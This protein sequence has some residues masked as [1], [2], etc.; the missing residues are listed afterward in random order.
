MCR[1]RRVGDLLTPSGS[2]AQNGSFIDAVVAAEGD[3]CPVDHAEWQFQ[4]MERLAQ[5]MLA[6]GLITEHARTVAVEAYR[7]RV[8]AA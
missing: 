8:P 3:G 2:P 6:R 1:A 7:R 5:E 4:Y